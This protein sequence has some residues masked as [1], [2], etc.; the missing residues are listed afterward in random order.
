MITIKY[1]ENTG[2]V[3]PDGRVLRYAQ[4]FIEK[5]KASGSKDHEIVIAS[6]LLL[7]AFRVMVIRGVVSPSDIRV[8]YGDIILPIRANGTLEVWPQGLGDQ[9]VR[10]VREL[11][12]ARRLELRQ[13]TDQTVDDHANTSV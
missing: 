7:T 1:D 9:Y 4:D 13:Q 10:L 8:Q 6:D 3:I 12:Q 2:V 5:C 11:G